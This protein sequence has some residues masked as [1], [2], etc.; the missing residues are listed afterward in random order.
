MPDLGNLADDDGVHVSIERGYRHHQRHP[1]QVVP[2][3]QRQLIGVAQLVEGASRARRSSEMSFRV[4]PMGSRFV[5]GVIGV[6]LS[7]S[8]S[9]R[10]S[11][12]ELGDARAR[13][14]LAPRQRGA[15]PDLARRQRS[16]PLVC[17]RLVPSRLLRP[18]LRET[19]PLLPLPDLRQLHH[20]PARI[21]LG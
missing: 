20:H 5:T 13:H 4:T 18:Q 7:Q 6:G 2:H 9:E 3:G 15:A 8:H 16:P 19:K 11:A 1:K 14:A 17:P 12:E 21:V 10:Q